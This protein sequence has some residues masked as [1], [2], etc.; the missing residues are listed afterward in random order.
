MSQLIDNIL[1]LD[2]SACDPEDVINRTNA[3]YD[4][5][6]GIYRLDIWGRSYDVI[7]EQSRITP[8]GGG[9]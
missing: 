6:N 5:K 8:R 1:F 3:L 9:A 4:E 2:L 7:P